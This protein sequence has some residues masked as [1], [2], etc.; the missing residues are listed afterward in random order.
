MVAST[1][2]YSLTVRDYDSELARTRVHVTQ[3][4]SGNFTAWNS[5]LDALQ[6]GISG[7]ILG[8]AASEVR[9]A[10]SSRLDA[11]LPSD[12]FAQRETKWIVRSE[13]SVTHEIIRNEIPTADLGLLSGNSEFITTFPVGPLADFKTAWEA[14]VV[15]PDGNPVSLVSL[16]AAGKRL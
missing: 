15:S 11:S 4:A 1:S 6:T 16:Q 7:I 13:D 2:E 8:V 12:K 3:L 14:A 5:A 9:T 10:A